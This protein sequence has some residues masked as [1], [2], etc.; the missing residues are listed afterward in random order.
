MARSKSTFK[1]GTSGNKAGKPVGTTYRAKFRAAVNAD[2]TDIIKNLVAG[3]KAG[4]PQAIKL[5]LDRLI[6]PLRPTSDALNIKTTGSLEKKGAAVI[7]AMARGRVTPDAAKTALD[8][9][10]VQARLVEQGEILARI[11]QLE[12]LCQPT[13]KP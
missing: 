2:L 12:A 3:A 4:D 13:A 1:P 11:E 7:N 5:V 10:G 9:M 6:P 8:A